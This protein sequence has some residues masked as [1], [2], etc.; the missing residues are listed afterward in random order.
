[1]N[2]ADLIARIRL[3]L[4]DTDEAAYT[5]TDDELT[6]HIEHAVREYSQALPRQAYTSVETSADSRV[7]DI[8]AITDAIVIYAI[9][10]PIGQYPPNHHRFNWF[11]SLLT[12]DTEADGTEA[13][14]FYGA[15]H[16][17]TAEESS[18]PQQHEDIIPLAA[19]AYAMLQKSFYTAN[20]TTIGGATT[21]E[22]YARRARE[23]L[24][25]FAGQLNRLKR[26]L[27]TA[28]LYV[29]QAPAIVS[30]QDVYMPS[31]VEEPPPEE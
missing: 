5:W 7:I 14:I 3:D 17:I 8:S 21:P 24:N 19:T 15:L 31:V 10:H 25:T 23:M 20:R 30:T 1:V 29:P 28:S 26:K 22:T 13:T 2:L 16:Y 9:E 18:I 6:R 4:N 12:L 27:R 11:A